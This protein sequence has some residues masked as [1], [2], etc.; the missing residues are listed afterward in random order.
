MTDKPK[1]NVKNIFTKKS[2]S[3]VEAEA[4]KDKEDQ[5]AYAR[6]IFKS[7]L[8]GVIDI[9]DGGNMT[10]L[11]VVASTKTGSVIPQFAYTGSEA[12]FRMNYLLDLAKDCVQDEC[13]DSLNLRTDFYGED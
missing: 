8:E 7:I 12:L 4:L 10:G 1:D 6:E 13:A 11:M 5:E 2:L 3:D 9:V